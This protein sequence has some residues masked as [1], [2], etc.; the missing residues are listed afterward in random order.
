MIGMYVHMHQNL[1]NIYCVQILAVHCQEKPRKMEQV[2]VEVQF[3]SSGMNQKKM[4][5]LRATSDFKDERFH[6]M[7]MPPFWDL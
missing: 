6:Q 5:Q 1:V 2:T 4:K 7:S 3:L